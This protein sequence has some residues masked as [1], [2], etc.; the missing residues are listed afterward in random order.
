MFGR[1]SKV[2]PSELKP[3]RKHLHRSRQQ[4]RGLL[5]AVSEGPRTRRKSQRPPESL[6]KLRMMEFF[7]WRSQDEDIGAINTDDI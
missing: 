3:W 1:L 6:L 4:L 2:R 7:S 5:K